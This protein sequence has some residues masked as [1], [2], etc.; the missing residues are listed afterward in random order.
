MRA[1]WRPVAMAKLALVLPVLV[2]RRAQATLVWLVLVR[3]WALPVLRLRLVPRLALELSRLV[4]LE[5][6]RLVPTQGPE[7][8]LA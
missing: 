4:P 7:Q 5:L 6:S 1:P 2:S 8:E 3:C